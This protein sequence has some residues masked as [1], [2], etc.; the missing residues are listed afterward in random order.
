MYNT[1]VDKI[2]GI[3]FMPNK[4]GVVSGTQYSMFK[5]KSPDK[6]TFDFQLDKCDKG[7]VAKVFYHNKLIEFAN[8]LEN[9]EPGAKFI[10]IVKNLEN[11]KEN[12][13]IVECIFIKE[14]QNFKPLFVRTDKNHP[15]SMRTI[16]RTLFNINENI[17]ISDFQTLIKNL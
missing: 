11:Y 4:L 6:H 10:S 1:N 15:N 12:E 8:I 13:C 17:K 14:T 5:W 3:I 9:T 7:L 16:E 2:D